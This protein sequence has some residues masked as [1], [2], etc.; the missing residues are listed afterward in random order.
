[1]VVKMHSEQYVIMMTVLPVTW[2]C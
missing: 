2:N 1:M